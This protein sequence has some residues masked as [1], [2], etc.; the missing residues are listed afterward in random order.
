M[1]ENFT[2]HPKDGDPWDVAIIGSGPA[3]LTAAIYT[4]RGAAS[5]L[6]LGGAKWG[7]QL[8]LTTLVDNYPGFP[9]GI[10]G[11]ELMENMKRQAERFGAKFLASD[12]ES[13]DFLSSP[14]KLHTSNGDFLSKA[15]II[16]TGAETVWLE[17][18]GLDQLIGRGVSSCAPCDAPFFK[19][20]KVAVVG[21]GDSAMEEALVLSKY[22]T[23]VTVIHRRDQL[24]ASSAMQ[25]K[26]KSNQKIKILFN[27]EVIEVKGTQ[28]L[29]KIILK[30]SKQSLPF[31]GKDNN[32]SELVLDGLFVAIGHSPSTKLFAGKI[33]IDERGFVKVNDQTK[34]NIEGIFTA[35]DVHDNHYKQAVTAAGFGCMAALDV[36]KYLD[37]YATNN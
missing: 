11:P 24:R 5:T 15:V 9:Q 25:Q 10:Q 3:S 6:I 20:K 36:L 28:K 22:A 29:E 35:G 19:D 17:V 32:Q 26:V 23:E 1:N 18:Q 37:N 12:V 13:V 7:G 31:Q 16:A 27:T 30:N 14:F 4:T 21:G 8:M 2:Q 33:D 34:T